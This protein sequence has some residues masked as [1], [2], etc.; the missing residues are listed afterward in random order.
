MTAGTS[1]ATTFTITAPFTAANT[2]TQLH[3]GMRI[4]NNGTR[5]GAG[6]ISTIANSNILNV[7]RDGVP[8]A[9]TASGNK[10]ATFFLTYE[11][12]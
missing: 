10:E 1:N 9:W 3:T 7:F 8:T 11:T 12:T 4:M 5:A 6:M 2:T